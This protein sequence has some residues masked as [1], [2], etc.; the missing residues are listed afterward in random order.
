[1]RF[2]QKFILLKKDVWRDVSENRFQ[3]TKS[4]AKY[5]KMPDE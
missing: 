2:A 5:A 1:M 3:T 4:E